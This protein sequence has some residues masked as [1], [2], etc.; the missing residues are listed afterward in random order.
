MGE[1]A[2][3]HD[4]DQG[5][6]IRSQ[7][8][9]KLSKHYEVLIGDQKTKIVNHS[10]T[11]R[12]R[13]GQPTRLLTLRSKLTFPGVSREPVAIEIQE[14]GRTLRVVGRFD[15]AM[16]SPGNYTQVF[17]VDELTEQKKS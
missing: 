6:R 2:M 8:D 11:E 15:C 14:Q 12:R 1:R 7:K 17:V 9:R 4:E 3:S 16:H 5:A 10:I 13:D